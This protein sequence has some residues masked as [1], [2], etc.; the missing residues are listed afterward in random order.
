M[1]KM[2]NSK[3]LKL[4]NFFIDRS[5]AW[6][7]NA[8]VDVCI[9]NKTGSQYI[10]EAIDQHSFCI[11]DV[12]KFIYL[13]QLFLIIFQAIIRLNFSDLYYKYLCQIINSINPKVLITYI[14]ND[15]TFWRID[16]K[17]SKRMKVFTIQNGN[18]FFSKKSEIPDFHKEDG[19]FYDKS[20]NIYHSNFVCIS[21]YEVDLYSKNKAEV[22]YFHPIGSL[23]VSRHIENYKERKKVFD[24]CFIAGSQPDRWTQNK[25]CDYLAKFSELNDVSICIALKYNHH[26]EHYTNTVSTFEDFFSGLPVVVVPHTESC[27][28]GELSKTINSRKGYVMGTQYLSDVSELTIGF[29]STALRQT[30]SRG[31]K[32]CP[33]N[34]ETENTRGVLG[35][36]DINMTPTYDEFTKQVKHLL[37]IE[38]AMYLDKNQKLM[39]YFDIFEPENSPE[40]KL[41]KLIFQCIGES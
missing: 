38:S 30:F 34:Y 25:V 17:F 29:A 1:L 11:I 37:S 14:D 7:L 26:C 16:K 12:E 40:E 33:I 18:R 27:I 3:L 22:G 23:S 39:R 2:R 19:Y 36:L 4:F 28:S 6:G 10:V 15:K 24:I 13:R 5:Y 20:D 21:N 32:I 31:N 41:Q 35:L 8:G 9:Y